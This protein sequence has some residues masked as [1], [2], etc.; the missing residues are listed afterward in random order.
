MGQ[1]R[2]GVPGGIGFKGEKVNWVP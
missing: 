1:G 2:Q